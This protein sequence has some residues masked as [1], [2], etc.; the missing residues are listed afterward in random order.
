M[1]IRAVGAQLLHTDSQTHA[2]ANTRLSHFF[3]RAYKTR[4]IH[5]PKSN[6]LVR[7][8]WRYDH[9]LDGGGGGLKY[10]YSLFFK[11]CDRRYFTVVYENIITF[12]NYV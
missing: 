1:K 12:Y 8:N 9:N 2:E 10:S 4:Q 5:S 6:I 7:M 3:E 11:T